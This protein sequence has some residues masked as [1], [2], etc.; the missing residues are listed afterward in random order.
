MRRVSLALLLVLGASGLWAQSPKQAP[1][2]EPGDTEGLVVSPNPR[3]RYAWKRKVFWQVSPQASRGTFRLIPPHTAAE[4]T[5]MNAT[6]D[7]FTAVLKAT[8]NG[9]RGEGFWV[10]DSRTL[11]YF[12]PFVLPETTPLGRVPLTYG[13]G[14]FPFHHED[15]ETNGTWRQSVRGETES[16]YF[17]FN[18]MP[19]AIGREGELL[20]EPRPGDRPPE[21]FYL[22][23]RV[24]ATWAGLPVYEGESLVV[25]RAGRDPWAPVPVARALKAA[26]GKLEKDRQT[27]ESRL[28]GYKAKLEEVTAPAWEQQKRDAFEKTNGELRTSRPSNYS[29]RQRSLENEI[30]VLR[31]QAQGDADPQ[32]DAKGAWY[33]NAIE[34]HADAAR[35]LA[36]LSPAEAAAP[37]CYVAL[38]SAQDKD[39]RYSLGGTIVPADTAP[40]CREIV[41]T[42]W[43]YFD[44]SLPRTAPQILFIRDFGRCAK[45]AGDRL[46]SAPINR[47]DSPPQGCVQH[48]QMWR[49]ADWAAIAALVRP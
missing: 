25:A 32:H 37:A 24:T 23:P 33:W 36:A 49:E 1:A 13:S 4:R 44:L 11:D 28:A 45:V 43:E 30:L 35:Q 31:Q 47:W 40:G 34:A 18:R 5:Q 22:R 39:G 46:D 16:V 48:A 21:P 42:N 26:M 9:S 17:D 3:T 6:L 19:G 14:L 15:L 10:M 7:A 2:F 27:A 12:D 20:A 8:P 41:R 38:T 29:A